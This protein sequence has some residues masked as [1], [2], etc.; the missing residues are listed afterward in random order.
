MPS[1]DMSGKPGRATSNGETN[2]A[3]HDASEA[4]DDIFEQVYGQL[5]AMA[6]QQMAKERPGHTLFATELV[7]QAYLRMFGSEHVDWANQRHFVHA[8]AE[9]M[10]RILIEHARQRGRQKRGGD[11]VRVPLASLDL[12]SAQGLPLPE[13]SD[14]LLALDDALRRLEEKD[15]RAADVVRL[16]FF[17]GLTIDQ[18]AEALGLSSRTVKR[19]WEF[20]RAWLSQHFE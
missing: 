10:R 2:R 17:A 11:R 4:F 7:H 8:A 9:A 12:E 16:R 20:A 15:A 14:Q 3:E 6:Q 1:H 19:E 13:D 5:R 18:A